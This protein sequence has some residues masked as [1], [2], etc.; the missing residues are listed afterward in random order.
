MENM[1]DDK[2]LLDEHNKYKKRLLRNYLRLVALVLF[3]V[4]VFG[5]G[6]E[7]GKESQNV[8]QNPVPIENAVFKNKEI[9]KNKLK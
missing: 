5:I 2:N 4:L 1:S 8:G 3:C 6:F 9:N 7:K